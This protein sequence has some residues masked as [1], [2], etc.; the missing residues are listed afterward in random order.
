MLCDSQ[1]EVLTRVRESRSTQCPLYCT[2][3]EG[4]ERK[5]E[6]VLVLEVSENVGERGW[7][8][9]GRSNECERSR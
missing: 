9:V 1:P 5:T 6:Y 7:R 3:I 2:E 4:L 8:I